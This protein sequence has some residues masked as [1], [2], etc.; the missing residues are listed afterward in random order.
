MTESGSMAIA[1]PSEK[2]TRRDFLYIATAAFGAIGAAASMVPF[3]SQMNPD[4]S[5]LAAGGPVELDLGKVAPGQQVAI[6]WRSRPVFVTHRTPEAVKKLKDPAL[7]ALLPILNR[8][9]CNSRL[10]CRIGTAPSSRSSES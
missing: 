3:I 5:T 1:A 4:A 7:L 2:A 6:R 9:N 8:P 10:M